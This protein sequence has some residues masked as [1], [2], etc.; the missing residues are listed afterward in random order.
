MADKGL[1][2]A[3]KAHVAPDALLVDASGEAG[4]Q[5]LAKLRAT[6]PAL[7]RRETRQVWASCDGSIA[8]TRGVVTPEAAPAGA[9][10]PALAYASVW[11]RQKKHGYH[12]VLNLALPAPA[13][14]GD[15]FIDAAV[16]Q[17]LKRAPGQPA[18]AQSA[19]QPD[20]HSGESVDHSLR[21]ALS[22][23]RL[24][25]ALRQNGQMQPVLVLPPVARP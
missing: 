11:Q 20:W 14:D 23:Q 25:I 3:L 19:P 9:K 10:P 15:D 18:A 7:A 22:G 5:G 24:E 4:P 17:C 1:A 12:L 13:H 21:W 6:P 8:I 2:A 16:A